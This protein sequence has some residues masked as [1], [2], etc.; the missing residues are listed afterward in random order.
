MDVLR[1]VDCEWWLV[2]S[3]MG[4]DFVARRIQCRYA[5]AP[6]ERKSVF[7]PWDPVLLSDA[8]PMFED[9][10]TSGRGTHTLRLATP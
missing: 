3:W 8:V 5:A 7:D 4:R 10:V 2:R 9:L 6:S 1:W